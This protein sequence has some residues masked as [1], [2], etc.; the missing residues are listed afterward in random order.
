MTLHFVNN[1]ACAWLLKHSISLMICHD[2]MPVYAIHISLGHAQLSDIKKALYTAEGF[3]LSLLYSS[4]S[5]NPTLLAW[6]LGLI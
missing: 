4:H 5:K 3:S 2:R 1:K 6:G